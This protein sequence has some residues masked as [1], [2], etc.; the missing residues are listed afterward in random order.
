MIIRLFCVVAVA[1]SAQTARPA[2]EVATVKPSQANNI[3][4]YGLHV[5]SVGP[6]LRNGKVTAEN[7]TLTTLIGSAYGVPE[8]QI[9]GPDWLGSERFDVNAKIPEGTPPDQA[10]PML[11]TLLEERF[12]LQT[13]REMAQMNVYALVVG[14]SG[15]KIKEFRAGEAVKPPNAPDGSMM[16]MVNGTLDKFAAQLSP[17]VGRP[18]VDKTGMA[19][20]F[21]VFLTYS[22][23]GGTSVDVP[24]DSGPDIANAIQEQLG[25]KLEPQKGPVE[26][27]KVDRAEKVPEQN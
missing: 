13:H 23:G 3:G 6:G 7:V 18:V 20:T 24:S 16:M 21:M 5:R 27:L 8:F 15:S 22:S 11:R 25:L 14:K 4:P 19:G 2:F 10:M 17:R 12:H 9:Q 1:A 26:I